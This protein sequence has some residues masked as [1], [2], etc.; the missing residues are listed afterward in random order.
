MTLAYFSGYSHKKYLA[1]MH[2]CRNHTIASFTPLEKKKKKSIVVS[3][4]G[5]HLEPVCEMCSSI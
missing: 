5:F 4:P 1:K 3:V 2:V